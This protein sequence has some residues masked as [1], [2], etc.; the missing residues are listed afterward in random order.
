M[1]AMASVRVSAVCPTAPDQVTLFD[2]PQRRGA[3]LTLPVGEHAALGLLVGNRQP[4]SLWLGPGVAA[5]ACTGIDPQALTCAE[6]A[7]DTG[8]SEGAPLR[9]LR[10]RLLPATAEVPAPAASANAPAGA[11]SPAKLIRLDNNLD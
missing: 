3:C 10:V 11:S 8:F 9:S 7:N 1:L 5:M 4:R 6:A 2:E